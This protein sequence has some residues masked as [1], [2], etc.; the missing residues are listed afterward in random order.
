MV[1]GL[2]P[3]GHQPGRIGSLKPLFLGFLQAVELGG[4][5][6]TEQE[7]GFHLDCEQLS[8]FPPNYRE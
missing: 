3:G 8:G 4:C 6:E 7:E 2:T 1:P 5:G